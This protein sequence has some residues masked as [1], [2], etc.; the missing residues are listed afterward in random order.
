MKLPLIP[1]SEFFDRLVAAFEEFSEISGKKKIIDQF[2]CGAPGAFKREQID[3]QRTVFDGFE[4]V[5]VFHLPEITADHFV[6]ER[7]GGL[8]AANLYFQHPCFAEVPGFPGNGFIFA[9]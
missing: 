6:G 7:E 3:H 9:D 1:L 8:H 4:V 5:F 2:A